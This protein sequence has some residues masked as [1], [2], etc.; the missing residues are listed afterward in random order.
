MKS[1]DAEKFLPVVKLGI[2][3][4]RSI[5]DYLKFEETFASSGFLSRVSR[6]S[7]IKSS[8]SDSLLAPF[9]F[10]FLSLSPRS[11]S[12][13]P[14]DTFNRIAS[15]IV[16][17]VVLLLRISR[18]NV[19]GSVN[20]YSLVNKG[21]W[22]RRRIELGKLGKIR[23]RAL[24]GCNQREMSSHVYTR[25]ESNE[26]TLFD[27]LQA[28]WET[29]IKGI[30]CLEIRDPIPD[31]KIPR[32]QQWNHVSL[33][34]ANFVISG[35]SIDIYRIVDWEKASTTFTTSV[36]RLFLRAPN[37]RLF[38]PDSSLVIPNTTVYA[39]THVL[40]HHSSAV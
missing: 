33:Y 5:R 40:Y 12:F 35:R 25:V 1:R 38:P 15:I 31:S 6:A 26:Y 20:R 39:V 34:V 17:T 10:P 28:K 14:F 18:K 23:V 16:I 7:S 3:K 9:A 22:R 32:S 13:V 24:N 11:T 2:H 27:P 37:L 4:L 29:R 8:L 30:S 21:R 19:T 36:P